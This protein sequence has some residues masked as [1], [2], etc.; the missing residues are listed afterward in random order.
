MGRQS[1]QIQKSS[2]DCFNSAADLV[3][4][5]CHLRDRSSFIS[6]VMYVHHKKHVGKKRAFLTLISNLFCAVNGG[7]VENC[8]YEVKNEVNLLLFNKMFFHKEV[9]RVQ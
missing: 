4:K 5:R 2:F 3:E 8:S 7:F 9:L 6:V 1:A